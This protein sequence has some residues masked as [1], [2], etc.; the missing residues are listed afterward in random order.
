M[1][2]K[3][4]IGKVDEVQGGFCLEAPVSAKAHQ[5]SMFDAIKLQNVIFLFFAL[6]DFWVAPRGDAGTGARGPVGIKG[7]KKMRHLESRHEYAQHWYAVKDPAAL[8]K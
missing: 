2:S 1:A 8:D 7:I 3:W 6:N 4:A 5:G